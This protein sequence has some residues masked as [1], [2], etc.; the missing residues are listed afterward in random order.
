MQ[1]VTHLFAHSQLHA[2][3]DQNNNTEPRGYMCIHQI[4]TSGEFFVI[5]VHN[6]IFCY[7]RILKYK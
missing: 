7:S 4:D 3:F 6:Q 1:I 5:M 2:V